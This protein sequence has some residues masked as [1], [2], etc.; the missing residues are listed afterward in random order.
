MSAARLSRAPLRLMSTRWP[1]PCRAIH[2]DF[3]TS[4][5]PRR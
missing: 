5:R 3:E 4:R 2:G 1:A